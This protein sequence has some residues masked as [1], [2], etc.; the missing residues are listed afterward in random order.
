MKSTDDLLWNIKNFNTTIKIVS[1]FFFYFV[2]FSEFV[3]DINYIIV[4]KIK[5]VVKY[6]RMCRFSIPCE[7]VEKFVGD[8]ETCF[9]VP[10][11]CVV[12]D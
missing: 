9:G 8:Y 6:C 4:I 11:F 2:L 7:G 12:I 1:Q 5:K 3:V 10:N